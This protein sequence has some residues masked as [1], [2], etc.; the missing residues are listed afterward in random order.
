MISF[1]EKVQDSIKSSI[2]NV[3]FSQT[4]I[5]NFYKLFLNYTKNLTE[6]KNS[7]DAMENSKNS[8]ITNFDSQISTLESQLTINKNNLENLET[9]KI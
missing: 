4:Q 3:Y 2:E 5:D 8:T 7:W 6:L 1:D 9:N